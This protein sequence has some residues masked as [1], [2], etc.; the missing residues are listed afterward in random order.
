MI[1]QTGRYCDIRVKKR[2]TGDTY[3]VV[4]RRSE[5]LSDGIKEDYYLGFQAVDLSHALELWTAI[6]KTPVFYLKDN[7]RSEPCADD[8]EAWRIRF[9][10]LGDALIAAGVKGVDKWEAK[11]SKLLAISE[12]ENIL[13]GGTK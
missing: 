2:A 8:D 7:W 13:D 1:F 12:A 6:K 4:I 5:N 10:K 9:E 11:V 3:W